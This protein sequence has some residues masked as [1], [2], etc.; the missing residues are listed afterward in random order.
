M[1]LKSSST[2]ANRKRKSSAKPKHPK[3]KA[4]NLPS[5]SIFQKG[6]LYNYDQVPGYLQDNDFIYSYYRSAYSYQESFRSFFQLHN[7]S[8]NI[9]THA[10]G[11]FLFIYLAFDL[12]K[13]GEYLEEDNILLTIFLCCSTYTLFFSS[14]F[15]LHLCVSLEVERFWGCLDHSGISASIAGGSI[16]IM[17]L[18]LH[19]EGS[20]RL[21]WTLLLAMCNMV[22]I[23]GPM[24]PFWTR[25]SFRP[26][27]TAI[28]L[29][30]G[31]A[32]F[33]PGLYYLYVNGSGK[34]PTNSAMWYL[35]SMIIQYVLGAFIYVTRVPER[36]WPG[37]F[38]LFLQ[39]HQIWH[40][41]VVSASF[42][43]YKGLQKLVEW[44]LEGSGNCSM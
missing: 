19:C 33:L 43:L 8:G 32:V 11:T 9:W 25:V 36:F 4:D 12:W 22:G 16:A 15:H 14:L 26:I 27:R 17:Y 39:S 13:H 31:A 7:Q 3:S 21:W 24:F 6:K 5:F 42:T 28:Y 29:S 18:L 38:D 37:K 10:F 1:P 34:L 23:F 20:V 40:V 41:L 35:L 30:S 44:R 2:L